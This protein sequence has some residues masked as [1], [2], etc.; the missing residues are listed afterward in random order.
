[1]KHFKCMEFTVVPSPVVGSAT[2]SPLL[3]V[4]PLWLVR[5]SP[6]RVLLL[7]PPSVISRWPDI[8]KL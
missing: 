7:A 4:D 3:S 6:T 2:H 5:P 1:M 8:K